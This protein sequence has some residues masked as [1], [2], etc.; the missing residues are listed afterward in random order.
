MAEKRKATDDDIPGAG[1]PRPRAAR[2]ETTPG[3]DTAGT[4]AAQTAADPGTSQAPAGLTAATTPGFLFGGALGRRG[5]SG[6][7]GF[8]PPHSWAPPTLGNS[9]GAQDESAPFSYNVGT[10]TTVVD[11]IAE[12]SEQPAGSTATAAGG[13]QPLPVLP[14]AP[15]QFR[16]AARGGGGGSGH[17][18]LAPPLGNPGGAGGSATGYGSVS[19]GQ[20]QTARP[21]QTGTGQPHGDSGGQPPSAAPEQQSSSRARAPSP[22]SS[23]AGAP[24]GAASEQQYRAGLE[25]LDAGL[26][27]AD[28]IL[29]RPISISP[30]A[31]GC[32][33]CRAL[34]SP[35]VPFC[36]ASFSREFF[37]NAPPSPLPASE[38]EFRAD[39][40]ALDAELLA[41]TRTLKNL[42][43]P[44]C[45]ACGRLSGSNNAC[46]VCRQGG[47][48]SPPPGLG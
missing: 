44:I 29:N 37:G 7:G 34:A 16:R 35:P 32:N 15:F 9:G 22:V 45:K 39:L 18:G 2:T 21:W 13:L 4:S 8:S 1:Q 46:S 31:P 36:Q 27:A 42:S 17:G 11:G 12:T 41:V 47:P 26:L 6:H 5:G 28:R 24:R 33:F 20:N 43:G 30:R 3:D 38:Q 19:G 48:P 25:A 10:A 40:E 14:G 23:Y